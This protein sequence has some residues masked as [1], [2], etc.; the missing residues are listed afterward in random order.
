MSPAAYALAQTLIIEH[1]YPPCRGLPLGCL[2]FAGLSASSACGVQA[3][4]Y[5]WGAAPAARA[6]PYLR[7]TLAARLQRS[8]IGTL[9]GLAFQPH[10]VRNFSRGP[11]GQT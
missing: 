5:D 2:A 9:A 10:S 1:G 11:S 3:P 4:D 7:C 6:Q 8:Q